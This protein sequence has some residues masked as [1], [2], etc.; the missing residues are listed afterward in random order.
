MGLLNLQ[1]DLT[2]LKFGV[3][4]SSDRPGSGNSNQPYIKDPIGGNN[5]PQSEDF[6]LRGG[7]NAPLD[8]AADVVRLT[9]MFFDW[10][11]P[12][13]LLFTS[14]QNLLSRIAVRTQASGKGVNEGVY[15]PLTT[16]AQAGVGFAG[17][18]LSKQGLIPGLGVKRYGPK[19]SQNQQGSTVI[20]DVI[21]DP[22]GEGEGNRLVDLYN[23]KQ[24]TTLN[25]PIISSY[26]GGPGS[27][28]GIG[29]T[30]IKF[31]TS[32]KGDILR[33]GVNNIYLL[34]RGFFPPP[35]PPPQSPLDTINLTPGPLGSE[36]RNF[37]PEGAD[38]YNPPPNTGFDVFQKPT[39]IMRKGEILFSNPNTVTNRYSS[40]LGTFD[41]PKNL[42]SGLNVSSDAKSFL[43]NPTS[44]YSSKTFENTSRIND[45]N[46]LT[47]DQKQIG[48]QLKNQP[49]KSNP[50]SAIQDFRKPLID[51]LVDPKISNIMSISPSYSEKGI[52]GVGPSRIKQISP[53]Q[54]GNKLNYSKGKIINSGTKDARVSV[55]D[56]INFQ[57]IYKSTD[58]REDLEESDLVQF[59]IGAVL[60]TKGSNGQPE[61]IYIHFRAFINSFTDSYDAKWDGVSYMGRGEEFYKYGGFGRKISLS[62]T[63]AAQSK[64][65]LMA[66]Y[67]KLNF[68]ASTLAPD[69]GTSGYMGGVLTT[70]TLG[71]WCYELPGF[72]GSLSLEIPKDSPWEIGINEKG[73][74]DETVKELPHICNVSMNFTPIHNFRPELQ[75]NVYDGNGEISSYT[76]QQY[77]ALSDKGSNNY[78]PISL[79]KAQIPE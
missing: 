25:T 44:V 2:S 57:P 55:V 1:T 62:Y 38:T 64:P 39:T 23:T 68:L 40:L 12:M 54:R 46:S 33:T 26:P 19:S 24:S 75:T 45:N 71:G 36:N 78:K 58:V 76:N 56:Q 42:K 35:P 32:N 37:K 14:K 34:K 21:G 53:G 66:Q 47:L 73:D 61:K 20:L 16:L 11:S 18:H 50:G 52:D 67:K 69:Y 49:N 9:K 63:I 29:N 60:R 22:D 74:R 10:K 8:A 3:K 51:N 5:L 27:T 79:A 28:L 13:G 70:L 59:R 77:I 15:T 41:V 43:I 48:N 65:E 4:S 31:A 72:I 6:L 7:L 30:N 17:I